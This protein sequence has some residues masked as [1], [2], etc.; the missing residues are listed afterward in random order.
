MLLRYSP[1]LCPFL[2]YWS[3]FRFPWSLV[4]IQVIRSYP[5]PANF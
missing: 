3:S 1:C 4:Q 5:T 2:T